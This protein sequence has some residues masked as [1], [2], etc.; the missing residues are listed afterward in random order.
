MFAKALPFI[1]LAAALFGVL[2][3]Y[4]GWHSY[5]GGAPGWGVG[6]GLFGLIGVVLAVLLWRLGARLG[7]DRRNRDA[8]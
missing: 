2:F 8:S 6:I 7:P 4:I 5:I 1:A 3:I